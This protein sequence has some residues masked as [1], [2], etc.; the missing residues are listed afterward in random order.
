MI[1]K[2]IE[3]LGKKLMSYLNLE[4]QFHIKSAVKT[5]ALKPLLCSVI[6][7]LE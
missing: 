4:H 1:F 2:K 5:Q 3:L 7:K 6:F